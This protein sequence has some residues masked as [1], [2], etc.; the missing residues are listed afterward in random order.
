[1]I[2]QYSSEVE[3][4]ANRAGII[5]GRSIEKIINSL[6]FKVDLLNYKINQP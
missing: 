1:M 2:K 4:F 3:G 5:T 6:L